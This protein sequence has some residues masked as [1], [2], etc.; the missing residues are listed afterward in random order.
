MFEDTKLDE[1]F[2][3]H[4][5]RGYIDRKYDLFFDDPDDFVRFIGTTDY[6]IYV[7]LWWEHLR[8]GERG[9]LGGGGY[10]D[11]RNPDRHFAE[12][13]L[14]AKFNEADNA[15]T[16]LKHLGD[17]REKYAEYILIPSFGIEKR[18]IK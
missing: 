5:I 15:V 3:R 12:T 17:S 11:P 10:I 9:R 4:I 16:I 1:Y 14:Q 7:V 2:D 18:T 8:I 6:Y 13:Y